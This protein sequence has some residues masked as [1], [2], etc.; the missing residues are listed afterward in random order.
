MQLFHLSQIVFQ[1]VH[2]E[3]QTSES[4]LVNMSQIHL[5]PHDVYFTIQ[6][7][8]LVSGAVVLGLGLPSTSS[9]VGVSLVAGTS[10]E[11]FEESTTEGSKERLQ[12]VSVNYFHLTCFQ[13]LH[14]LKMCRNKR[15]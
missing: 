11:H 5:V 4:M 1:K 13:D 6:L 9:L 3:M 14:F 12:E 8:A 2:S 15:H 10:I 7:R